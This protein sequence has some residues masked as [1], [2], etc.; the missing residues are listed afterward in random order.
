MRIGILTRDIGDPYQGGAWTFTKAFFKSLQSYSEQYEFYVYYNK[1]LSIIQKLAPYA[2]YVDLAPY[3]NRAR[4]KKAFYLMLRPLHWLLRL[5]SLNSNLIPRYNSSLNLAFRDHPVDFLIV[6]PYRD[7]PDFI[8]YAYIQWDCGPWEMPE[9][10]EMIGRK[11]FFHTCLYKYLR[12][13]TCIITGTETG[14]KQLVNILAVSP[15]RVLVVPFPIPRLASYSSGNKLQNKYDHPVLFYPAQFWPHK[16]HVTVLKALYILQK[17][18]NLFFDVV[19]SGSDQGNMRYIQAVTRQLK[20]SDYVH[21]PGFVSEEEIHCYYDSAFAM[22]YASC[23]GPDNLP[24]LEAISNGCPVI[25][26]DYPGAREQ[27]KDSA[28]YFETLDADDLAAKIILLYKSPDLRKQMIINGKN[29]AAAL[30]QD[31]ATVMM[32]KIKPFLQKRILW[33]ST[34]KLDD[35]L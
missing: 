30:S 35:L 20:L 21:F 16:N 17:K 9:F 23:L 26:S 2:R 13:A 34:C 14:K 31:Y 11:D 15:E 22:I 33:E 27:M 28:L 3:D 29:F 32:E 6:F 10:P 12:Y 5:L 25:I 8:P 18:H 19:F 7:V 1:K 4:L 24:P